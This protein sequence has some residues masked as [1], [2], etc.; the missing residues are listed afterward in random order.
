MLAVVVLSLGNARTTTTAMITTIAIKA[1][2][3]GTLL[4]FCLA[5]QLEH[6][7]SSVKSIPFRKSLA[8]LIDIV[9]V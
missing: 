8:S 6:V 1:I 4:P 2:I 7:S 3:N 5:P 9:L